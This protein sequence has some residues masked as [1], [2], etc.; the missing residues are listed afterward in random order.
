MSYAQLAHMPVEYGM[1][2]SFMGVLVYWIFATSKDI[3]IGVSIFP[4]RLPAICPNSSTDLLQPVAVMS[5][6]VGNIVETAGQSHPEYS[7][8]DIGRALSI[9]AGGIV[10]AMGFLRIGFIVDFIPVPAIC[11]FMTG[12]SIKIISGQVKKL[13]GEPTKQVDTGGATYMA[14]INTLKHLPQAGIDSAVGVSCLFMLYFIRFVCN[15]CAKKY[16]RRQKIIFFAQT[17]R[18]VFALLFYTMIS[19]AVNIHRRDNP[20]IKTLGTVPRGEL[21][22]S[23]LLGVQ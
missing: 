6:I 1:Y 14:I 15:Y 11:A 17:M 18:T 5:T 16:P 3:T 8:A 2:T 4:F 20:R 10:A 23:R 22:K 13:L 7:A 21:Y 19:A 12:S 9:I